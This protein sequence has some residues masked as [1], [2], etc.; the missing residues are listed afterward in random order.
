MPQTVM[1][2]D[3]RFALVEGRAHLSL[4]LAPQPAGDGWVDSDGGALVSFGDADA[5]FVPRL[6]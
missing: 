4:L 5:V 6:D 3:V 1:P 2:A